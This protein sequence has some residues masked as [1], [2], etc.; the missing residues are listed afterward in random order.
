M[1][2]IS[3]PIKISFIIFWIFTLCLSNVWAAN[4]A[5]LIGVGDYP[6]FKNA[7]LEGPVNDVEA[8]KNTLNSKFGFASGNIVTLTDQKATRERILGSLRD[9]NRTTKPGDFI[10]FYF[11]G[12]GTSSYDAGNKKLGI[13]PYTGA[14]VPTD[15]GSGKTI[16][17][18]MAKLIIGKRDIRPILEKLEKGRRILAVF[19]ACYSQNTVR[20]I[21]RH[22]RYKNRYLRLP[23]EDLPDE[24]PGEYGTDTLGEI[25]Y[26]YRNVVYMAA[27]RRSE[28]A[29]DITQGDILSGEKKTVDNRP[30][31]AMTDAM[32]RA[33]QGEGDTNNDGSL[34]YG[35]LYQYVKS[36][37]AKN[38]SHTPQV[39][40]PENKKSMSDQP[41]F[42]RTVQ[43]RPKPDFVPS[44]ILRVRTEGLERHLK[45]K[46]ADIRG[47]EMTD[48]NY[49]ILIKAVGEVYRL[50]LANDAML[51]DVPRTSPD[52]VTE[53]IARQ[54]LVNGLITFSLP[55]QNFNVSVDLTEPKGVLVEGDSLGFTIRTEADSYI[56]LVN[57]DTAGAV[58]VIYPYTPQEFDKI[59]RA[60]QA[61][62]LPDI[63]EVVA[64]SFGTEH[65]KVFA[66]KKRPPALK[67]FVGAEFPPTDPLLSEL[68]KMV[69]G[70]GKSA[71]QVTL[72]VK[73]CAKKDVVS[74]R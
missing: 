20:S 56:L 55:N 60:G 11:S 5:L 23:V 31:G 57:I 64:P 41:I 25:P 26:P 51:T 1:K 32:L 65:L 16:Q 44:E 38:F 17:D 40:Y 24:E 46:I 10:F 6:H 21:R 35:E 49:D 69:S 14:L 50:Y 71:A 39:L 62:H 61:L 37:V 22:T 28:K 19:D 3:F 58:N 33:F 66:F 34:T 29:R 7:Q 27:S 2:K 70:A 48:K 68:M 47:V 42:D 63:G 53:R 30:H 13:D 9:L 59:V 67:R 74:G 4:H 72:Q 18:M 52:N 15:F 54:V 43:V 36:K 12:H 73:T 8:L 45:E